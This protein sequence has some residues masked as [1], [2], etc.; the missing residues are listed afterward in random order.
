MKKANYVKI[1]LKI[2]LHFHNQAKHYMAGFKRLS[3][4]LAINEYRALAKVKNGK[5]YY[6]D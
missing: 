1:F 6:V 4:K 3:I 5:T 2:R